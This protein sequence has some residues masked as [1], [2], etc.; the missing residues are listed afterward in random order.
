MAVKVATGVSVACAVLY[1]YNAKFG[2][3]TGDGFPAIKYP[4]HYVPEFLMGALSLV[5]LYL[6]FA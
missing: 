3:L 4:M 5:G 1:P 2:V 6:C